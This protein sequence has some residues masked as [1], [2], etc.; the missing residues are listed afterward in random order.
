M[1]VTEL[2]LLHLPPSSLPLSPSLKSKLL[3]AKQAMEEFTSH[4]FYF[5]TQLQD[6]AYIHII[7]TWESVTQ[8][9]EVWIPS[10]ENQALLRMLEGEVEVEWMGHVDFELGDGVVMGD[11][12][13]LRNEDEVIAIERFFVADEK[14]NEFEGDLGPSGL[15]TIGYG[16]WKV[17]EGNGGLEDGKAEHVRLTSWD[18]IDHYRKFLEAGEGKTLARIQ[19]SVSGFEVKHATSLGL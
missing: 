17:H 12:L 3:S 6:P 7:G 8:H 4:T 18:S 1:P 9:R 15:P 5:Y 11:V 16:G 13:P 2:A 10:E 14:T 19:E